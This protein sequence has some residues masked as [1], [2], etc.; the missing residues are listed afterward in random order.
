MA[1]WVCAVVESDLDLQARGRVSIK[2]IGQT[3]RQGQRPEFPA[4]RL[5]EQPLVAS[6]LGLIVQLSGQCLEDT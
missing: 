5:Q 3:T 2:I 6:G 4:V 1:A